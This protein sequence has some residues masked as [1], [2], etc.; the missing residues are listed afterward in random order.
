MTDD[1]P[2]SL[3]PIPFC[4]RLPNDGWRET[5]TVT[6]SLSLSLAG[7]VTHIGCARSQCSSERKND[8]NEELRRVP[9]PRPNPPAREKPLRMEWKRERKRETDGRTDGRTGN[10][11]KGDLSKARSPKPRQDSRGSTSSLGPRWRNRLHPVVMEASRA[12][13]PPY[14]ITYNRV[15]GDFPPSAVMCPF[16]KRLAPKG[17]RARARSPP[18]TPVAAA[19]GGPWRRIAMAV[20][21]P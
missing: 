14:C 1:A 4:F 21:W 11:W 15:V 7:G 2:S 20:C 13:N 17:G 5:H 3:T 12:Y 18:L 9:L 16:P 10:F 19:A 6:L 8:G